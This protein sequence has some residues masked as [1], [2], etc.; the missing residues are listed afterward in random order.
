MKFSPAFPQKL[1]VISFQRSSMSF[2]AAAWSDAGGHKIRYCAKIFQT[3]AL[4]NLPIFR[5]MVERTTD[6]NSVLADAALD[7]RW[8]GAK[9]V[10][11]GTMAAR[12]KPVVERGLSD[13][14][15]GKTQRFGARSRKNRR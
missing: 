10:D 9:M 5:L 3:N 8:L 7:E 11:G 1:S 2:S 15:A 12:L 6:R 13:C 4:R 14:F